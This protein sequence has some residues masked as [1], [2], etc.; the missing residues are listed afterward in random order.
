MRILLLIF[1]GTAGVALLNLQLIRDAFRDWR[2]VQAG[3]LNGAHMVLALTRIRSRGF[4]AGLFIAFLWLLGPW[5]FFGH[6]ADPI[7]RFA[8]FLAIA[9]LLN[10]DTVGDA[11]ERYLVYWFIERRRRGSRHV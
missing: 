1:L 11:F 6:A 8:L 3:H 7:T 5:A 2:V 9:A 10:L 4:R